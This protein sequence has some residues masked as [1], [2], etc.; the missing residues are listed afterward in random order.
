MFFSGINYHIDGV[1]NEFQKKGDGVTLERKP[2][3]D[4]IDLCAIH[5]SYPDCF[6]NAERLYALLLD[7]YPD[8]KREARIIIDVYRLPQ[9][10]EFSTIR[11]LT[12]SKLIRFVKLLENEYGMA[13]RYALMAIRAWASYF[14][15]SFDKTVMDL[16]G[17]LINPNSI[18][19]DEE[20]SIIPDETKVQYKFAVEK[21]ASSV[22]VGNRYN[23]I[24]LSNETEIDFQNLYVTVACCHSDIT[25]I[26][27]LHY[28]RLLRGR[29]ML[30]VLNQHS[31]NAITKVS[32]DEIKFDTLEY[33]GTWDNNSFKI[34][35][36][37]NKDSDD[38]E[39]AEE[40]YNDEIED[41]DIDLEL[42]DDDEPMEID[43][44]DLLLEDE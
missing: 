4:T 33:E 21:I 24:I 8:N 30:E 43:E 1:R 6:Q 13:E 26:G 40:Y 15:I 10:E 5:D 17:K 44:D 34:R 11:I 38:F 25:E 18:S 16:M 9:F 20:I 7:I 39:D 27:E 29:N 22:K 41:Y 12:G 2:L 32:I 23:Q 28:R 35:A 14:S 19:D 31:D 42:S 3:L 36:R 37:M